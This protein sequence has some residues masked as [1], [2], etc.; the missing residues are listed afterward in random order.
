MALLT[1]W[2]SDNSIPFLTG[3]WTHFQAHPEDIP[4]GIH[5][6]RSGNVFLAR[7]VAQYFDAQPTADDAAWFGSDQISMTG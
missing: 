4:D 2:C 1:D 5:P 3:I 6:N 7:L